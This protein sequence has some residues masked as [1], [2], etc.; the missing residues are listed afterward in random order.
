MTC[1]L[2]CVVVY[3]FFFFLFYRVSALLAM[4]CSFVVRTM[5]KNTVR[6][7]DGGL[8]SSSMYLFSTWLPISMRRLRRKRRKVV[9]VPQFTQNTSS[10]CCSH[11]KLHGYPAMEPNGH[12]VNKRVRLA[13]SLPG[14]RVYR[15]YVRGTRPEGLIYYLTGVRD[16]F[17]YF[18]HAFFPLSL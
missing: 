8:W 15:M 13:N 5:W 1:D 14:S 12:R 3:G 4:R 6:R 7:L 9:D 2:V 17:G 16:D 10:L 18:G 11:N